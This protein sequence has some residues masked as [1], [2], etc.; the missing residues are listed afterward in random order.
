M[1][2][3]GGIQAADRPEDSPAQHY[4]DV[5]GG[6]GYANDPDL[7]EA[8][9]TDAP[10]TIAWL[11]SLGC[12]F[13]KEPDGTLKQVHGGGTSR[14]R[15]HYARDYSGAEIM[16]TLRDELRNRSPEG[17]LRPGITVVEFAP[18]IELVMD[19]KG[20]CA[21]AI[22][23]NLETQQTVYIKAKSVI[24][25]TG[26]GGRLH[27]QGFPTTNHYGATADG[28]VIAYRVGAP[29]AFIDT[30]QFHPTGA[31][32][33]EQI[34]GQ[35]VTEK[36]RSLGAQL[37]NVDGDSLSSRWRRAT[38]HQQRSSANV[39]CTARASPRRRANPACGL[40]RRALT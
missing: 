11:E 29:L 13:D 23:M 8:L 16:R 33:P 38:S 2:A 5:I 34:L 3:Q 35:L 32:F 37:C 25:A 40:I 7:V 26:G 28:L 17:G 15:M 6:G 22:S 31:A 36:V 4:L 27:Y 9:V 39:R 18:I 21:G 20:N 12:M 10:K 19:D 1:M 24:I 14:K 30:M